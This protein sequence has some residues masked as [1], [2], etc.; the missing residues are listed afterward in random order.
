MLLELPWA[1]DDLVIDGW[2]GPVKTLEVLASFAQSWIP[3]AITV[4][5]LIRIWTMN[6]PI[7]A[8][9]RRPQGLLHAHLIAH[10]VQTLGWEVEARCC[11]VEVV[12]AIAGWVGWWAR[13]GAL[14]YDSCGV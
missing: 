7:R 4:A 14:K 3:D 5:V 8:S 11:D 12:L 10:I 1:I 6:H 9:L 13:I 2:I